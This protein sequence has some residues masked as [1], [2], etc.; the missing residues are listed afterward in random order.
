MASAS[1]LAAGMC[2]FAIGSDSAGSVR[3]PAALC[4]LVGFKPS[5]GIWS[6][7][8]VFS[9]SPTF[10]TVGT[11]TWSVSDAIRV[12]AALTGQAAP[13]PPVGRLRRQLREEVG[14]APSG[15][16]QEPAVRGDAHDRLGDAE[17]D[18]LGVRDPATGVGPSFWQEVVGCAI[19]H[20]AESVEVGVHRGLSVDGV[21]GTVGFGLSA[22]L[23]LGMADLVESI[24]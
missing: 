19:N 12:F 11:L 13:T 7:D 22:L 18:E 24:I 16:R 9:L 17:G 3:L 23:S 8:G 2:G 4:G 10:D 14:E 20:R 21:F 15:H 6:T 5:M 1:T